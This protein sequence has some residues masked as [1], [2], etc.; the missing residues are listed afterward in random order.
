MGCVNQD[1]SITGSARQMLNLLNEPYTPE[2][3]AKKSGQ[4]LF[5]VRSSLR[6]M[7]EAGLIEA[8]DDKYRTT[9]LGREKAEN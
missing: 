6:E 7:T 9:D 8:V 1:G 5:K 4:P 3:A 2:E